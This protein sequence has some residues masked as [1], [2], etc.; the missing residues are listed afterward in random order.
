MFREVQS[1]W[2]CEPAKY[3]ARYSYG[4]YLSHMPIMWFVSEGL[5]RQPLALRL[6]VFPVLAVGVP[7]LL[8]HAVEEPFIRIGA[9]LATRLGPAGPAS[10]SE[11]S[12]QGATPLLADTCVKRDL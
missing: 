6:A 2:L 5:N 8:Y 12:G 1:R 7:M 11:A 9:Q 10:G 3:V 4:I